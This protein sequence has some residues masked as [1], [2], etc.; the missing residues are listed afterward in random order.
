MNVRLA[1]RRSSRCQ[2][3]GRCADGVLHKRI[4]GGERPFEVNVEGEDGSRAIEWIGCWGSVV[5]EEI[6]EERFDC[7][8]DKAC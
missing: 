7:V 2:G 6:R 8:G 4:G 5:A 3:R 1:F